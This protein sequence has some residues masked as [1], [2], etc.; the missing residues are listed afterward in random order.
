M[1]LRGLFICPC[2]LGA[3]LLGFI[4]E[5]SGQLILPWW[6]CCLYGPLSVPQAWLLW[7][8]AQWARHNPEAARRAGQVLRVVVWMAC[9][10]A[11]GALQLGSFMAAN[12]GQWWL[13]GESLVLGG[14]MGVVLNRRF[15]GWLPK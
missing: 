10:L 7:R 11:V 2:I 15:C 4:L 14:F 3:Y 12:Q 6:V 5:R 9:W 1:V 8:H 13:T